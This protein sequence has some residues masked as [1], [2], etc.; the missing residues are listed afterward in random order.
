MI[1]VSDEGPGI[2]ADTLDTLHQADFMKEKIQQ[3]GSR[4]QGFGLSIAKLITEDAGGRFEIHSP[5]QPQK[6]GT[7][8]CIKI[9]KVKSP[10]SNVS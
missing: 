7:R 1:E 3:P 2:D 4:G 8:V 6:T 5:I 9:P 10:L